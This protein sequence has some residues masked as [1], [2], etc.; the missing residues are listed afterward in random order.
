VAEAY[1][2]NAAAPTQEQELEFLRGEAEWLSE[3][4]EAVSRRIEELDQEA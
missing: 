3:R 2:P 1:P 4:L